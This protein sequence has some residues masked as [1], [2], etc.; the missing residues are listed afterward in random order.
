MDI[1]KVAQ[2]ANDAAELTNFAMTGKTPVLW[3]SLVNTL[4]PT[5]LS[6]AQEDLIRTASS[7]VGS[8]LSVDGLISWISSKRAAGEMTSDQACHA[9]FQSVCF[10]S[11]DA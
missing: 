3:S 9:A 2:M 10:S 11:R 7:E 6:G 8:S 5:Q 1:I 4:D